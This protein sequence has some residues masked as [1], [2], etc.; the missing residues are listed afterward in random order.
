MKFITVSTNSKG[1][2]KA[3]VLKENAHTFIVKFPDGNIVKRHK[4]KHVLL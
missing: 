2:L 1:P 4:Q 3:E